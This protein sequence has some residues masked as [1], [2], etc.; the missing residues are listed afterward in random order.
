MYQL[1]L[2]MI[3]DFIVNET[4]HLFSTY[5]QILWLTIRTGVYS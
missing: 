3:N 2:K 1:Q 4:T 5:P